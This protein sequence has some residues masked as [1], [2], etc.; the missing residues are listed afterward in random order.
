[1][2]N[3]K[4]EVCAPHEENELEKWAL[5]ISGDKLTEIYNVFVEN[6]GEI[7]AFSEFTQEMAASRTIFHT[8]RLIGFSYRI[9]C[10]K[11]FKYRSIN[12]PFAQSL[13]IADD[14]RNS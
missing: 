3:F 8:P 2:S 10:G 7:E 11:N 1:M 4:I 9:S 12:E 5:L 6:F 13:S 14:N